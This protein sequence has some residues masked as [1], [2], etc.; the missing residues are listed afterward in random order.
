LTLTL[1]TQA[2]RGDHWRNLHAHSCQ[3]VA[4]IV[5]LAV[6]TTAPCIHLVTLVSLVH[7]TTL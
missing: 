4:T 3:T 2:V 7:F 5:P 6:L 1:S